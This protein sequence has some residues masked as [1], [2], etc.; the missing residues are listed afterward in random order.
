MCV[1][2]VHCRQLLVYTKCLVYLCSPL[3]DGPIPPPSSQLP[4]PAASPVHLIVNPQTFNFPLNL[5][6]NPC[7][8]LKWYPSQHIRTPIDLHIIVPVISSALTSFSPVLQGYQ[9]PDDYTSTHFRLSLSPP[10]TVI[11]ECVPPK[12]YCS[13]GGR[14]SRLGGGDRLR[15]GEVTWLTIITQPL[16]YLP[17]TSLIS[18]L[19]RA[20]FG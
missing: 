1:Y 8:L 20:G 3:W 14:H 12:P 16:S 9:R 6:T 7:T 5:L 18:R 17:L 10:N 2:N 4:H 11:T 15:G 13:P 19:D